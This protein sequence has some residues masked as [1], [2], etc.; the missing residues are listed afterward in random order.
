MP[1]NLPSPS[2]CLGR[3]TK[4]A[5]EVEVI[6]R[7]KI[8][9]DEMRNKEKVKGYRSKIISQKSKKGGIIMFDFL[10]IEEIQIGQWENQYFRFHV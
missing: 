2:L 3:L 9:F 10:F 8:G 5:E 6:I 1:F 7:T 4:D